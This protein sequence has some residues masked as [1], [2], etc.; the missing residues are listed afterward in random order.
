MGV[1]TERAA[2]TAGQ[3]APAA[4]AAI[5]LGLLDGVEANVTGTLD[6]VDPERLHDLRVGVRRTRSLLKL[7]GDVLPG[8]LASRYTDRFR[9]LGGLTTPVRDLDVQLLGFDE[10]A[11]N[12]PPDRRTGLEPYRRHLRGER[13]ARF[14]QL[15]R[16]LTGAEFAALCDGWRRELSTLAHDPADPTADV[17]ARERVD[18]ARRA[19]TKR[20]RRLGPASPADDLHDLRKRAKELRYLLEAFAP[21]YGDGEARRT[22]RALKRLQDV[23]GAYQDA[24]VQR[25]AVRDYAAGLAD[26]PPALDDLAAV[27]ADRCA[28]ARSDLSA[29]LDRLLDLLGR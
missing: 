2:I 26:P 6:D 15:T 13:A 27:L 29:R 5:L 22:V 8:R 23:L 21:V 7:T 16:E 17:L 20:A 11:A 9:R 25:R 1:R 19:V 10:L 18:R 24:Q 12:L 4:V 14:E 3:S 28:R